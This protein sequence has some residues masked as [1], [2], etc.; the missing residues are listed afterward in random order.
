[1]SS[2]CLEKLHKKAPVACNLQRIWLIANWCDLD[3][4]NEMG[5]AVKVVVED[6]FFLMC[7]KRTILLENQALLFWTGLKWS[8]KLIY[9]K[10]YQY[11]LP[12]LLQHMLKIDL[13]VLS[14]V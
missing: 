9:N 6:I 5:C 4:N 13:F 10:T 1:M 12:E 3:P 11:H 14:A 2:I 8:M 7:F